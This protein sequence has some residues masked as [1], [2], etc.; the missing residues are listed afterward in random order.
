MPLPELELKV[1]VRGRH[2]WFYRK[3]VRKPERP[4][5]AGSAVHVRDR[6]GAEVGTG[7][8][9]A[10]TELALRMFA[11]GPVDDVERHF[12]QAL[13]A[14]V[15]LREDALRLPAVTDAYR[16]VHGEGDGFPALVLDRL[17][18]AFVAQVGSLGMFR[19]MELLGEWLLARRRGARLL[20]Q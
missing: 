7:F 3:M 19:A 17:G 15:A 9:N 6:D 4:I 1:R 14:A 20:L 8:F 5:P 16:L 12:T 18:D 11:D 10:R 2:P 13:A